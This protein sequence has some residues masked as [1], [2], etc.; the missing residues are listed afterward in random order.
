MLRSRLREYLGSADAFDDAIARSLGIGRT[1][2]RCLDILERHGGTMTA[3]AL[4]EA[5]GLST[6]AVTFLLDRLEAGG[7]V[8]RLRDPEDRRRVLV[9]LVPSANRRVFGLHEPMVMEMRAL[10][11]NF[12]TEE[13]AIV[14]K[15]LDDARAIYDEALE[16]VR[17]RR[18]RPHR[19]TDKHQ[20][21]R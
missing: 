4:A 10:A 13:L 18:S 14:T 19:R 2:L 16:G 12:K 3:G 8:R 11:Q 7:F 15:F 5:A 17:G 6:G 20:R 1:D 21:R 9:D